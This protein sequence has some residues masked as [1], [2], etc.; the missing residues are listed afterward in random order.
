MD[1]I[2]R[3]VVKSDTTEQLSP[4]FV[5]IITIVNIV[6]SVSTFVYACNFFMVKCKKIKKAHSYCNCE[7][8]VLL[9]SKE[10]EGQLGPEG[11][12]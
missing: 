6:T 4:S 3:G 10:Q 11:S 8:I 12:T 5:T 2:V 1:C 7:K 9:R